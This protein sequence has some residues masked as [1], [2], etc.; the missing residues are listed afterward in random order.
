MS[1]QCIGLGGTCRPANRSH[2]RL[3]C[4][5]ALNVYRAPGASPPGPRPYFIGFA[6]HFAEPFLA[7]AIKCFKCLE[8]PGASLNPHPNTVVPTSAPLINVVCTDL[9]MS[10]KLL[11]FVYVIMLIGSLFKYLYLTLIFLHFQ[12]NH[13]F[14]KQLL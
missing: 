7:V 10:Y 9:T 4:K 12:P 8:F 3:L 13:Q 2:C 6:N 14:Y 5:S 11:C 1:A